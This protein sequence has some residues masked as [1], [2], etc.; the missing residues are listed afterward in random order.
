MR[1][2]LPAAWALALASCYAATSP[3][4]AVKPAATA[5]TDRVRIFLIAPHDGGRAGRAAGCGDS[6][7][8]VEVTLPAPAPAL[9][10]ALGALLAGS[11]RL[12][13]PSGLYDSLHGSSL[14]LAGI[15][16]AGG[17]ARVRLSG[18]LELGDACEARRIAAQLQETALQFQGIQRATFTVDG[19]PLPE[20]LAEAPPADRKP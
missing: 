19:Q 5:V 4:P 6:A 11:A 18:Y 15:E 1:N 12:D 10:G 3:P 7:V 2:G 16:R 8:P 17:E 9:A 13:S 14:R 20:L